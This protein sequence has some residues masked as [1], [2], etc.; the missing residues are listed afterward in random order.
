[1]QKSLVKQSMSNV[2]VSIVTRIIV[3]LLPFVVRTVIIRILGILYVGVDSLFSSLLNMLSLS[4]LGFS[5]AIVYAMYKP[6]AE[7]DDKKVAALLSF[8]KNVYRIVGAVI[9]AVGLILLPNIKWFI[10]EGTEYPSNINLYIIY[11][12][13]LVNTTASYFFFAYKN[14]LLIASMR[15]D[16]D[17]LIDMGRSIL[18][19][20]GQIILLLIF[21]N[22]YFYI[23]LLPII[24]ISND[25]VRNVIINKRYPQYLD[26][27][28]KLTK[29]EKKDIMSRVGAL[30]GHKLGGFV[31]TSVDSIIISAFLGLITLGRYSNYYAIFAAVYAMESTVYTANCIY[32]YSIG[33]SSQSNYCTYWCWIN[34]SFRIG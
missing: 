25:L 27:S 6:I 8:Y 23:A 29:S 33:K 28:I 15:N 16:I 9:L 4:E 1:M 11:L 31:F 20:V 34:S 5:S 26:S 7:G 10:A 32:I 2:I 14:S 22:Y 17:S 12:I 18:S 21:K 19:H 13:L 30:I 3:M 24:T